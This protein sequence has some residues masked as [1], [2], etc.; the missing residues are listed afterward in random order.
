MKLICS[1]RWRST[2]HMCLFVN[3]TI[4]S[5][6]YQLEEAGSLVYTWLW[7]V[8]MYI[9]LLVKETCRSECTNIPGKNCDR[10][11]TGS[12]YWD[13]N[14]SGKRMQVLKRSICG[15]MTVTILVLNTDIH[16]CFICNKLSMKIL[17][18]TVPSGAFWSRVLFFF[19]YSQMIKWM[20]RIIPVIWRKNQTII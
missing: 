16:M 18:Q 7:D 20:F 12:T 2:G 5:R 3:R 10:Y 8:L 14:F 17:A 9:G 15:P 4:G 1:G 13:K 6:T 11:H 19:Q